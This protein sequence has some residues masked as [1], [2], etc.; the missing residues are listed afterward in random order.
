MSFL[1]NLYQ[2]IVAAIGIGI[3]E[4]LVVLK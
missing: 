1:K 2:R 3:S 4:Q